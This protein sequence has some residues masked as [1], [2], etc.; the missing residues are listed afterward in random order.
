MTQSLDLDAYFR[1]IGYEGERAATLD[2]LQALALRHTEAIAFENLNPLLGW[3]VRLDLESLQQ[4]VVRQGRGGYCFEQNL[5]LGAALT[6]LGFTVGG[7]AARVL[8]NSPEGAITPR[9]HML[10]RVDLDTP[11]VVDVGFGGVTLTGALR[12]EADV[13]QTTPH[14]PFRLRGTGDEFVM[15][16]KLTESWT[17][18]YRFDLQPQFLPDYEVTNWYLSHHP[19][20]HFVNGL[21]VARPAPDRRFALRGNQLAVHYL[22]GR[23]ERRAL[24]T[25]GELRDTLERDFRLTLPEK[26]ELIAALDRIARGDRP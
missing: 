25:G 10:L 6:A 7:L 8:W 20:S 14:E 1:R 15:Q 22:D 9:G 12:L 24:E 16:V 21:I 19:A 2:V 18:L 17:S 3:P 5:L 23:T 11:Y 4:K 26:P 13:E